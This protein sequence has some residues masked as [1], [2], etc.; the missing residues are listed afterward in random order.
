MIM[1]MYFP[2]YLLI[3]LWINSVNLNTGVCLLDTVEYSTMSIPNQFTFRLYLYLTIFVYR[4]A[5]RISEDHWETVLF[6]Q[7]TKNS[8]TIPLFSPMYCI[9]S[10]VSVETTN[11]NNS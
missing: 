8:K 2:F 11:I 7:A 6:Y 1:Y 5:T 10:D 9:K 3:I 4:F